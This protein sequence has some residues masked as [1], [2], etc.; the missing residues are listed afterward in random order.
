MISFLLLVIA[1]VAIGIII[2][3]F[4]GTGGVIVLLIFGDVIIGGFVVYKIIKSIV[5]K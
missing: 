2:V 3:L 5:R 1:L 4:A